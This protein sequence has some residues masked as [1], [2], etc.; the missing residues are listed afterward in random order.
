MEGNKTGQFLVA[1]L[2][3][4]GFV[5]GIEAQE[6][7]DIGF[8]D[9]FDA[10]FASKGS[11]SS[12]EWSGRIRT[13]L[14]G[15]PNYD[16][17][18]ESEV[19]SP[20]SVSLGVEWKGENSEVRVSTEIDHRETIPELE[21]AYF[22]L[23]YERFDLQVGLMKT[24]WGTGDQVHVVDVLNSNDYS[25]F[26]NPDYLERRIALPM[27]KLDLPFAGGRPG[28]AGRVE[29][30]LLPTF[31]PDDVPLDGRWVPREMV[32]L[33][34]LVAAD[35]DYSL[36][37]NST[38]DLDHLQAGFRISLPLGPMDLA[39]TVF[40]GFE[41]T[42]SPWINQIEGSVVMDYERL[43]VFGVDS[44][45]VLGP[46]NT[47]AEAAWILT[48]DIAGDDPTV[49]NNAVDYLVGFDY[50]LPV[51][52]LNFNVQAVG[53]YLLSA[54]VID[55]S[56]SNLVLVM[57][58]PGME[59]NYQYAPNGIYS[60]TIVS[61]A[62]TDRLRNERVLPEVSAASSLQYGDFRVKPSVEFVL[63]DDA[64]LE[65]E[66]VVYLGDEEG[67]FGRYDGNDYVQVRFEVSF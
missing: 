67:P 19:D 25:D 12:I 40:N 31:E 22:R 63:R 21:E 24:V 20:V 30:A 15:Y 33:T 1:V 49:P 6:M 47:R 4:I 9:G 57:A 50:D 52:S 16:A 66:G 59:Y 28:G 56:P 37:Y 53:R 51:S 11:A 64:R 36:E 29:I 3:M 32:G 48:K 46:L 27:V 35:S 44:A 60:D 65:V 10:G 38:D 18:L 62:L 23:F 55:E 58:T 61:A 7:G 5:L 43:W 2:L 13:D 34:E 42:P 41:K 45:F 14:R 8:G 39:A 54:D 26:I 17:L